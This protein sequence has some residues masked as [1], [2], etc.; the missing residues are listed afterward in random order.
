YWPLAKQTFGGAN[1]EALATFYF[2]LFRSKARYHF[3]KAVGSVFLLVLLNA[4]VITRPVFFTI[5]V[6]KLLLNFARF[7]KAYTPRCF[8]LRYEFRRIITYGSPPIEYFCNT[9]GTQ[10]FPVGTYPRRLPVTGP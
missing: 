8:A 6:F 4:I 2:V 3:P 7:F 5:F 9:G 10:A 1:T